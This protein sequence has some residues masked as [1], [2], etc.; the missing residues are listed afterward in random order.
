MSTFHHGKTFFSTRGDCLVGCLITSGILALLLATGSYFVYQ[1]VRNIAI[2]YTATDPTMFTYKSIPEQEYLN[3]ELKVAMFLENMR[4]G[5]G[6][7]KIELSEDEINSLINNHEEFNFLKGKIKI[8]LHDDRLKGEV[9]M[10]LD[11]FDVE[12]LQKRYLNGNA[13]FN[14][15]FDQGVLMV[16]LD[17]VSVKGKELPEKILR[18]IQKQNLAHVLYKNPEQAEFVKQFETLKIENNTLII[19]TKFRSG[20][21]EPAV[22]I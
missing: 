14:I 1:K 10:P 12:F 2:D 20:S 8:H 21:K 16:T 17:S 4:Q 18:Q 19:E 22:E 9:S 3:L 13:A 7:A 5:Q 6:R 15:S 11:E